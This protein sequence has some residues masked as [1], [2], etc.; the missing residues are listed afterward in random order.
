MTVVRSFLIAVFLLFVMVSFS[1]SQERGFGLGVIIGEPT[2]ISMKGWLS[3]NSA[4]DVGVAWSFVRE[5]SFH[6][7]ADYLLHSFD[8]F[9]TKERIPLYYGIGGRI[10]TARHDDA[11]LGLRM[12]VGIGYIFRDAPVDLFLEVAPILDLAPATDL[13]MNAGFGARFFFR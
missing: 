3:P 9:E 12:V 6:V 1:L 5:T 13:S 2:G 4:I 7:H 10:K 11:R 8:V